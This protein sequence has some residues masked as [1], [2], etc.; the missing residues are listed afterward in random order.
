[1]KKII[2]FASL[3]LASGLL[4]TNLYNSMVDATSWGSNIPDSIATA[5]EY[6]RVANPGNFYR[7]FSP[8]NQ[9]LGVL[10]LVLFWKSPRQIRIALAITLT[11]YLIAE[12][13][14]FQYFYPRNAVMFA[15][16][17]QSDTELLKQTWSEW[18][19]MNWVRSF[20]LLVGICSSF[21]ALDKLYHPK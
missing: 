16:A 6:Y 8:I 15:S 20:V 18:N 11:F 1:M 13:L 2:L 3:S 4:F 9:L 14:T 12:G 7:I 21:F 10:V 5:K 17:Q 19:N